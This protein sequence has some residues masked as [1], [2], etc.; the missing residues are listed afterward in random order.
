MDLSYQALLPHS[1]RMVVLAQ[2]ENLLAKCE[3]LDGILERMRVLAIN[4]RNFNKLIDE[5]L[6]LLQ[7]IQHDFTHISIIDERQLIQHLSALAEKIRGVSHAI[8]ALG[9]GKVFQ[10]KAIITWNGLL[11]GL[12][13]SI[14]ATYQRSNP[15]SLLLKGTWA[16]VRGVEL[17]E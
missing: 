13:D 11:D 9:K 15:K 3:H 16:G 12:I 14:E 5:T 8:N 1:L 17:R 4:N 10:E 6:A 2:R 7:L